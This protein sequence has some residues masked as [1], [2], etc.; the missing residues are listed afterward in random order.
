[1]KSLSRN[2]RSAA[3]LLSFLLL[4]A[5]SASRVA[6]PRREFFQRNPTL[7]DHYVELNETSIETVRQCVEEAFRGKLAI[8]SGVRKNLPD[9]PATAEYLGAVEKRL[10]D[11]YDG[12]MEF[13]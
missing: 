12:K 8:L 9:S 1:M 2:I 10:R 11:D 7:K 4:V 6:S 3:A 5:C 13:I